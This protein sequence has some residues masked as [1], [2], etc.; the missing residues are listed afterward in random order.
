MLIVI[1]ILTTADGHA[2]LTYCVLLPGR[3]THHQEVVSEFDS[4][5]RRYQVTN[6][7]GDCLWTG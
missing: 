7:M 2:V 1:L 5:S 6:W 3:W 4:W